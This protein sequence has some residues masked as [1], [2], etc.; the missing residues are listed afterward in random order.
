[1]YESTVYIYDTNKYKMKYVLEGHLTALVKWSIIQT[2]KKQ[3]HVVMLKL[4]SH[5]KFQYN[6]IINYTG[7]QK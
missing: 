3:L 6:I 5:L 7:I 2:S 1:M 4:I